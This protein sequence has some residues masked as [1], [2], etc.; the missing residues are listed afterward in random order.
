[1]TPLNFETLKTQAPAIFTTSPSPKMSNKYAFVPTMDIL[2]NFQQEGW[3]VY[4]AKQTGR[5][6]F[7]THEIRLRNGE[8]PAVGDSLIEAVIRNSHNG[9]TTFSVSSGLHRLVCSNGLT[10]PTS[11]AEQFNIRHQNFDLGEVRRLTDSFASRLPIIQESLSKMENRELTMDEKV[12]FVKGAG[13]IR[14][15]EGNM[16]ST[17]SIEEILNP[18]RDG[19]IG[20]SLWKVFNV[21]QEK[22]V[23]GGVEYRSGRGRLTTMRELKNISVV[24]NVN[25]KLWE[26]AETYC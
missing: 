22:M 23:R 7:A 20:N 8:L 4:S 21:V 2:G 13:A 6:Q 26:L 16:P 12:G 5:S 17:M 11:L 24:N 25:T 19:D 10:V 1:M 3:Q 14:W 15:R 18:M 9:L